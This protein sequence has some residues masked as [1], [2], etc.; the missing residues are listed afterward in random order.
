[1]SYG[2]N[3]ASFSCVC[4]SQRTGQ[5]C[6]LIKYSCNGNPCSGEAGT[7]CL[8]SEYSPKGYVCNPSELFH[9]K[10]V[11]SKYFNARG[12]LPFGS[13]NFVNTLDSLSL[14]I[15]SIYDAESIIDVFLDV[16]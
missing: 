14:E 12:H 1:M 3:S 6:E 13:V 15:L 5:N 11:S 8:L 10:I 7:I 16:S 4:H 2:L 9:L